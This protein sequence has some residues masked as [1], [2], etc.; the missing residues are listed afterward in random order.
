MSNDKRTGYIQLGLVICFIIGSFTLSKLLKSS[1]DRPGPNTADDRIL[2]VETANVTPQDY[3]ITFETSGVV[4]ARNHINV[5]PEVSGRVINVHESFY[6][7]G[8][9]NNDAVLFEIDPRDFQLDVKRLEAEVARAN[10]ALELAT[11]ESQA[12]IAEWEQINGNDAIPDLVAKRPQLIEAGANLQAA[13]AMLEDARL[14]LE[15]TRFTLPFNGKVITSNVAIGQYVMAGQSY[16]M[17]FDSGSLEVSASLVDKQLEWLLDARDP[18]I[19]IAISF[20]GKRHQYSGELKR[21][22][23]TVDMGTRFATVYFTF[24]EEVL[25]LLPGVFTEISSKSAE[26]Q[27]ITLLPSTALQSQGVVWLVRDGQI[28]E[29]WEPEIIYI[30]D[31]FIAAKGFDRETEVVTSRIA[32]ATNGMKIAT[33]KSQDTESTE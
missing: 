19:D 23:S 28:L 11:A 29:L 16:G 22:A 20:L 14:N 31:D 5:V 13:E 2:I 9:F 7:G 18:D 1:Y 12:A 21:A 27:G 4:R 33:I 10:T 17:V 3:R 32:G 30:D 8:S 24:K 15:R 25:E 6:E 26:M